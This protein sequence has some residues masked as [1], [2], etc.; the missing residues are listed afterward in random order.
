MFSLDL[1][2]LMGD[3]IYHIYHLYLTIMVI[4]YLIKI[5]KKGRIF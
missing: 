2:L 5:T 4:V 3:P 1:D